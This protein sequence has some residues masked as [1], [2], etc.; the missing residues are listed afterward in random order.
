MPRALPNAMHLKFNRLGAIPL[1]LKR[2]AM[3]AR[4]R[5]APRRRRKFLKQPV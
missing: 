2:Q 1:Q 5:R 4:K 3:P